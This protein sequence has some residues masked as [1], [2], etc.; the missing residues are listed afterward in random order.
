MPYKQVQPK[1]PIFQLV[2]VCVI[3]ATI[4]CGS[5]PVE[6]P[7]TEANL[8]AIYVLFGQ[9]TGQNRGQS[10]PNADAFK[11][12]L[13]GL[14][15]EQLKAVTDKDVDSLFVS[16]RDNQPYVIHYKG[17][18][19]VPGVGAPSA[20]G[21]GWLAHEATGVDGKRYLLLSTGII[22]EVDA[23]RFAEIVK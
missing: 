1:S 21:G 23:A 17:E 16:P 7:A 3:L 5:K 13:Q 22:E 12:F 14:D 6:Q 18:I 10:P 9:Y 8:K 19:G 15:P 2:C 11:K 4:G 20:A